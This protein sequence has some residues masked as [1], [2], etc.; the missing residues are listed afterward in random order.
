MVREL[1]EELDKSR[2][3]GRE[4]ETQYINDLTKNRALADRL[5][6]TLTEVED[7]L[8][9]ESRDNR[10]L[11]S[12]SEVLSNEVKICCITISSLGIPNK[13]ITIVSAVQEG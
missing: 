12:E 11:R 2:M 13:S 7:K 1:G 8:A 9:I 10:A 4:R 3:E 6:A 5:R